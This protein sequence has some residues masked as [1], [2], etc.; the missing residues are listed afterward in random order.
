MQKLQRGLRLVLGLSLMLV[1]GG[2]ALAQSFPERSITLLV[3]YA[4]GGPADQHMRALVDDAS[5]ALGQTVVIQNVPGASGINGALALTRSAPDGYTLAML[6]STLYREPHMT[7]VKYDPL[8]SFA[9]ILLMSDYTQGVAVRADAP[10]RTWKDFAAEAAKRPG[11]LN[12]GVNGAIGTPRI[13]MEEAAEGSGVQLNMV[14]FKG[15]SEIAA[16]LL[17][18]HI[19]AAPLSGIASA[20][21]E[22]GKMRYLV[23]LTEKRVKRYA[24]VPTLRETGT[25]VWMSSPYGIGAPAGTDP[26]RLKLLHDAF[27]KALD[28]A[29]SLKTMEQLNQLMNYKNQDDYRAFVV[30]TFA[31][32]KVRVAKLR[33]RGLLD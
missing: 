24:N 2:Q 3:P 8:T 20:H 14:P 4:A 27:R 1:A 33:A 6:P 29:S 19:D 9:Y 17:G 10:W 15:D 22:A 28:G 25:D 12:I 23:M 18:G 21:I 13:V 31:K 16:A 7:A 26:A 32:E 11:Q 30:E 5:K